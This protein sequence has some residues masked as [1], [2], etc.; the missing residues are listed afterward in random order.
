MRLI[1]IKSKKLWGLIDLARQV[2]SRYYVTAYNGGRSFY[3]AP[4]GHHPVPL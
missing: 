3:L 1:I 2:G 4:A